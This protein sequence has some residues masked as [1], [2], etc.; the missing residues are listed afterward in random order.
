MSSKQKPKTK[1]PDHYRVVGRPKTYTPT[2]LLTAANKYFEWCLKNPLKEQQVFHFKGSITKTTV[3]KMRPFTLEGLC[4]HLKIVVNTYKNYEKEAEFLTVATRIRQVIENQQFE[5]AAAGFLNP[6][7]VAR[8]LGLADKVDNTNVNLEA[9]DIDP[10]VIKKIAKA[11][12]D[13]Y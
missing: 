7:I 1:Q 10:E 8:K 3:N 11:L 4:N 13:K 12:E 6:S 5:G 9:K 2:T